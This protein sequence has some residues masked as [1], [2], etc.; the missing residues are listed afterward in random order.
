[1]CDPMTP[2]FSESGIGK[3][4][5]NSQGKFISRIYDHPSK[6]KSLLISLSRKKQSNVI[7][8]HHVTGLILLRESYIVRAKVHGTN[9]KMGLRVTE[10]KL[11]ECGPG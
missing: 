9:L 6:Y 10:F 3:V 1:M 7:T 2:R 4:N 5:V 8:C 11:K